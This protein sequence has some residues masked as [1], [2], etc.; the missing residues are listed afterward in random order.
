MHARHLSACGC[1][2]AFHLLVGIVAIQFQPVAARQPAGQ[3][4]QAGPAILL[5]PPPERAPDRS[6]GKSTAAIARH[7][8]SDDLGIHLDEEASEVRFATFAFKV[9]KI[10]GRAASLF[11]FLTRTL[12]IGRVVVSRDAINSM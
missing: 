5:V 7:A 4:A 8:P 6:S 1:S 12:S 11:P 9:D 3:A 2:L 10:T